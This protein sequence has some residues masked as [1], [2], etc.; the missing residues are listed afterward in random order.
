[1]T[2]EPP[3]GVKATL[4]MC[5]LNYTDSYLD[6]KTP[7]PEAFKKCLF[8]ICFFHALLQDRRTLV[9]L[10]LQDRRTLTLT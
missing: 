1:M 9:T 6:T 10:T 3:R 4:S 8:A 5:Y 7:K 2:V